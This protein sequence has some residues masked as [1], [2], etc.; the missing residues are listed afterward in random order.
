METVPIV[1]YSDKL[2]G[3]PGDRISFMVSSEHKGDFTAQLFRSVNADPNPK[4]QG[5]VEYACD[6]FFPKQSFSSRK[7][8]FEPG[9]YGITEQPLKMTVDDNVRF[10]VVIFPTLKTS[11]PQTLI[12]F[13][14]FCLTLDPE[15]HVSFSLGSKIV[16]TVDAIS[17]RCWHRVE[18]Q[19]STT[20]LM[21][22]ELINLSNSTNS[23]PTVIQIDLEPDLNEQAHVIIAAKRVGGSAKNCFNGKIEHPEIC[24]DGQIIAFWDFSENIPSLAVTGVECP[25]LTLVNAP[26]RAVTGAMWDAS[27]MNW[28]HKPQ[29]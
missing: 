22:I 29:H 6:D 5:I 25:D 27:E 19:I 3:R 28:Q 14:Q 11:H 17:I 18:A 8:K 20:G 23:K 13:G 15:G 9:S 12:E 10:S 16:T 26:T 21:S 2:S 1:G 24:A 4:G 7:Q